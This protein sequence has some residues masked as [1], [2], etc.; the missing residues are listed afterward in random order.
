MPTQ[1]GNLNITTVYLPCIYDR[2]NIIFS[3]RVKHWFKVLSCIRT[4]LIGEMRVHSPLRL[5]FLFATIITYVTS[6][7]VEVG[8][9]KYERELKNTACELESNQTLRAAFQKDVKIQYG[10][11]QNL[12][13]SENSCVFSLHQCIVME[14]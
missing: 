13:S 4:Y 11:D 2:E 6:L 5:A 3:L 12:N 7:P 9:M 14:F 8:K 10:I 1:P